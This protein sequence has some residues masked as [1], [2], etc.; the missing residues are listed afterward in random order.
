MSASKPTIQSL[1]FASRIDPAA[2]YLPDPLYALPAADWIANEFA[3]AFGP[4]RD[5]MDGL[6]EAADTDCD[7]FAECATF[8][9]K[10]LHRRTATRPPG[11]SLAFGE[12][13]YARDA[14]GGHAINVAV[15][16]NADQVLHLVFFEPQLA[17]VTQLSE[18]EI[19]SC[20]FCRF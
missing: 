13:W 3:R 8:F 18:K 1:L 16:R 7:D 11:T 10:F 5:Q 6:Y 14:G 17:Q 12:F 15:C 19:E 2:C 4:W 9:A 20:G